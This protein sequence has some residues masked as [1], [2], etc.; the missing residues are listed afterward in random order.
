MHHPPPRGGNGAARAA[1]PAPK[2][3]FRWVMRP[4]PGHPS[5]VGIV[6][7]AVDGDEGDYFLS[8]R[9][10]DPETGRLVFELEKMSGGTDP[11]GEVYHVVISPSD[12]LHACDCRGFLRWGTA[13]KHISGTLAL[14]VE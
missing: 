4:P 7:L 12:G 9:G 1:R 11:E 5:P 3:S 13:C 14:L 6:R 2:R 8:P 10:S